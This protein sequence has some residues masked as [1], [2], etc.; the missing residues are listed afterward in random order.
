MAPTD[1]V[2][3]AYT[4]TNTSDSAL[5][6]LDHQEQDELELKI[7]NKI[8]KTFVGIAFRA[9]FGDQLGSAFS[10]AFNE[11]F[12]DPVGDLIGYERQGPC[13]GPVFTGAIPFRGTDIDHLGVAPLTYTLYPGTA[14]PNIVTSKYPGIRFARTHTDEASHDTN[15][16]GHIAVTDVT[17]SIFRLPFISLREWL[18][19]RFNNPFLNQGLR[20][21]GRPGTVLSI[22]SLLGVRP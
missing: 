21:L 11:I 18:P 13:N 7:L 6:S 14:R 5:S 9:G 16:C 4:G 1:Q 3:V 19:A 2:V 20:R 12:E 22:K 8:A 17:F 15:I 10:D